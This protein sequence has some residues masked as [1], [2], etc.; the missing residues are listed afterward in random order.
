MEGF[1]ISQTAKLLTDFKQVI[2]FQYL[3]NS[4]ETVMK[5]K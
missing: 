2:P 3:Q 1:Q 4:W 5:M